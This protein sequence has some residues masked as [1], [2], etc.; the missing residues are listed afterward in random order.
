M[1]D[2]YGKKCVIFARDAEFI[3]DALRNTMHQRGTVNQLSFVKSW[4]D[5]YKPYLNETSVYM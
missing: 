4:I 5:L 2:V 3:A 1:Y